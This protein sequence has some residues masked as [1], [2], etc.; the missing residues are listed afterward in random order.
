MQKTKIKKSPAQAI[1]VAVFQK[2]RTI[3]LQGQ[4]TPFFFIVLS[5]RVMLSKN[6]KRIRTLGE[7][8]IFGLEGLLSKQ[9][10]HYSA[11]AVQ[12]CRIARY[13]L[14]TLDHFVYEGPRMIQNVLVSTARQLT[15]T[16]L[17][18]LDPSQL[19][20]EDNERIRFYEDGE[21]ILEEMKGGIELYRLI[22]TQGGLQ[23]TMG[24]Q[25]VTRIYKPGE[26]FGRLISRSH[27]CVRSI[28]QSVVEKFG[29]E[30]L[31]II[32]R[33]YPESALQIMHTLIERLGAKEL[34]TGSPETA[35][36]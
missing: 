20:P 29:A 8:D 21:V 1:E 9:P 36:A 5:G 14:E 6:G 18:L 15:E 22:S 27:A 30:D 33:D 4:E 26:F 16:T 10:S 23:V 13:G 19:F 11:H 34:D 7:L 31:D 32:I 12:T 28:G 35:N 3:M 24:G 2:G 17:N 25:A